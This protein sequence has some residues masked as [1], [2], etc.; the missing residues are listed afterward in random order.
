MAHEGTGTLCYEA[1]IG[2]SIDVRGLSDALR[3]A[4]RGEARFD[5]GTRAMYSTDASN[6]RQVPI[7]VIIPR[8]REDIIATVAACRRFGAPVLACGGGT[9]IPGQCCNVAV[10]MDM[11]KYYNHIL[12]ID[13]GRK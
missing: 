11:S 5:D 10:V 7:G 12:E 13:P 3:R 9:S 8:T 2:Q 4:V 6:Y 1:M